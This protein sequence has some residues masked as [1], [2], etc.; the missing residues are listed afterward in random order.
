MTLEDFLLMRLEMGDK[1]NY[2]DPMI[3]MTVAGLLIVTQCIQ[4]VKITS[5]HDEIASALK[6]A[7]LKVDEKSPEHAG[8]LKF[9]GLIDFKKLDEE[10]R[11]ALVDW[12]YCTRLTPDNPFTGQEMKR[13]WG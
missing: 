1:E 4:F 8:F 5:K 12:E 13:V 7:I 10:K 6:K 3:E 11:G 9:F 2:S